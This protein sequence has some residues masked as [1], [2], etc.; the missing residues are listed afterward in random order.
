MVLAQS[1]TEAEEDGGDQKACHGCPCEG[2][3]LDTE[4]GRLAV[5]PEVVAALD[6]PGTS[7]G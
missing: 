4:T 3:E 2:V 5:V 7:D 1:T 6:S